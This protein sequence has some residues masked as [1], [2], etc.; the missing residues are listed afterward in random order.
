MCSYDGGLTASE[1]DGKVARSRPLARTSSI[2]GRSV[3][4]RP[5]PH[6]VRYANVVYITDETSTREI[7]SW[8]QPVHVPMASLTDQDLAD[9]DAA[10][11]RLL[12]NPSLCTSHS[13]IVVDHSTSMRTSDVSDFRNRAQAVFGTL[14]LDFVAKQRFTGEG[15]NTDVV[16]LVL[17]HDSVEIVFEREPMG[18][19]LYNM[20]VQIHDQVRPRSH[21]NFLPSIGLAEEMLRHDYHASKTC[22]LCLLFLSDG[23][24]SDNATGLFRGNAKATTEHISNCVALV[25]GAF[26]HRLTVHTLGFASEPHDFSVLETM[27][28]ATR[29]GGAHGE[30]H[31][32][33]LSSA[34]L[35][36]AIARSV[37][38]L[39]RTRS[40][41]TTLAAGSGVAR[42]LRQVERES[43]HQNDL[44]SLAPDGHQAGGYDDWIV[45]AQRV[46][47]FEF[48]RSAMK[49][50]EEP[51]IRVGFNSSRATGIA[52]HRKAFGEG[53]ERL[54]FK[55]Q[56]CSSGTSFFS[57]LGTASQGRTRSCAKCHKA[58]SDRLI[59][60]SAIQ[61]NRTRLANGK[62]TD[63]N[64]N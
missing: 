10:K 15:T 19:V 4:M 32:P 56:V 24:P 1:S 29:R 22:A 8:V 64:S 7:T 44:W 55:L 36:S 45:L 37:S 33:K 63:Q 2:A 25:A 26:G 3:I 5:N 23:R 59:Q 14:A 51:W 21:G 49:N 13:V 53:A 46:K 30:F 11:E 61:L 38:S 50:G 40:M 39:S 43:I 27:A 20:F 31:R 47:R 34:G 28:E 6:T 58:G 35:G 54:V 18:L 62:L 12:Q 57:R 42:V 52:I 41:L 60:Q 17:M 48:S 9:H 16:S